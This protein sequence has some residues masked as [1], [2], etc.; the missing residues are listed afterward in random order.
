LLRILDGY[1]GMVWEPD[2]M[3]LVFFWVPPDWKSGASP[4]GRR[5]EKVSPID[6]RG[7]PDLGS[8]FSRMV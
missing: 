8:L 4:S 2:G 7:L 6:F 5:C 3:L 1:S